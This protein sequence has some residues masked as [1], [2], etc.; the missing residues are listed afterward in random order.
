MTLGMSLATFTLV[1]VAISLAGLASGFIVAAGLLSGKKLDGWTA[2]FLATTVLT[3][4]TGFMFPV[5]HL[6]PSHILGIISLVFLAVAAGARYRF[7]LAGKWRG[8]YAITA[9]G[10]LYFNVFVA[11]V[12]AFEKVPALKALAPNGGGPAFLA[13]QLAALIL[14]VTLTVL[15]VRRF[16]PDTILS[17]RSAPA[18]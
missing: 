12:Q 1:H 15:A 9:L 18:R 11:I 3:S 14:F 13:A 10:S 6:M 16:Y 5:H 2:I 17:V 8:A 7:H 4:V